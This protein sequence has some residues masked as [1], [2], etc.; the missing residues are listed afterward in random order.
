M[1]GYKNEQPSSRATKWRGDPNKQ[2]A[3]ATFGLL[4][5]AYTLLA[6]TLV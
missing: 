1:L 2:R 6:M 5:R 4:R 3:V